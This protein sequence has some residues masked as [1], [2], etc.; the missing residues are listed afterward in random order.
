M[1]V[2]KSS[3]TRKSAASRTAAEAAHPVKAA[4][5]PT[6]TNIY[7]LREYMAGRDEAPARG[8]PQV[9]YPHL[10][11]CVA[12]GLIEITKHETLKLTAAGKA[13]IA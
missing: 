2:S 12:A 6:A 9:D 3:R 11:R 5:A 10:R 4:P 13:A 7:T 1:D 8:I